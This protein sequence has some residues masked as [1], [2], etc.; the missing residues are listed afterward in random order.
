MIQV[1]YYDRNKQA[2][3]TYPNKLSEFEIS[4]LIKNGLTTTSEENIAQYMSPWSTIYK[5]KKDAKENCPYS[6]KR[7]NV[8]IFKNIKTGKFTRA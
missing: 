7:G 8:V 5:D 3:K 2:D 4:D 1:W 6:K